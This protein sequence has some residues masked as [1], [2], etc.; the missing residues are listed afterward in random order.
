MW[1]LL[2]AFEA[3]LVKGKRINTLAAEE[4]E[5]RR[6]YNE[7]YGDKDLDDYPEIRGHLS[8]HVHQ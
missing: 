2:C 3:R 6:H 8:A 5:C 4:D 7:Q 1:S